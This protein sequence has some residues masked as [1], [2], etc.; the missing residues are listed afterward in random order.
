MSPKNLSTACL[1]IL[2]TVLCSHSFAQAISTTGFARAVFAT[3][4]QR[5]IS[6]RFVGIQAIEGRDLKVYV[7][8]KDGL[9]V[10][11][12]V[13]V[14]CRVSGQSEQ[15]EYGAQRITSNGRELE[16]TWVA[17]VPAK[18]LPPALAT[19]ELSA[20]LLTKRGG[21]VLTLGE[22]EPFDT[23]VLSK[24]RARKE[25]AVF[26][27]FNQELQ[28]D[29]GFV[30][31]IGLEAKAASASRLRAVLSGSGK[32]TDRWDLSLKVSVGPSALAPQT[33][34][35]PSPVVLGF[36]IS[37]R[38]RVPSKSILGFDVFSEFFSSVDLSLPGLDGHIG[39]R[40]GGSHALGGTGRIDVGL[41][42]GLGWFRIDQAQPVFGFT[43]GLQS[44][45]WF[46]D[47]DKSI[48]GN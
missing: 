26:Q 37:G 23:Q 17:V 1:C 30:G 41:G 35:T 33:L 45:V 32:F 12:K 16:Q 28:G 34:Q 14:F 3:V 46:G 31:G 2:G 25:N 38:R 44:I 29:F 6:T 27:Q 13:A 18:H 24:E 43:G 11:Q 10:I 40:F 48:K 22:P 21:L 4:G 19:V 20:H 15:R 5:G 42:G 9:K 36:E 8:V 7:Q 39:L 47:T